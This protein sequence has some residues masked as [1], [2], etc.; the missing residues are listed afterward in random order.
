MN[1]GIYGGT[2]NPPHLGHLLLAQSAADQLDLDVVLFVPA[3]VSP[4]KNHQEMLPAALRCE[5]VELALSDNRKFKGEYWEALREETSYSVDTLRYLAEQHA[6][7]ALFLL[8]G[9]D[10]FRDF[11][12][13]KDPGIIAGLARLCVARRPGHA[14][15]DAKH[16]FTDTALRFTMPLV[17]ISST[18]IRRRAAAGSSIQYLVPW[19]VQVFIESQGLYRAST[20]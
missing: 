14:S 3:Y 8:M 10:T 20:S 17:D 2:F 13:W 9:E 18:D 4:F 1:I 11:H 6:G 19:T 16:A 7:D 12:L 5:M 15:E